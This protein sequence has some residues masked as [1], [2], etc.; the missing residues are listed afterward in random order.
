MSQNLS[1]GLDDVIEQIYE[2]KYGRKCYFGSLTKSLN[3]DEVNFITDR[4]E[5]AVFKI[6][7]TKD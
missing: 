4:T 2:L 6:N 3:Y 1:K 5:F 7:K